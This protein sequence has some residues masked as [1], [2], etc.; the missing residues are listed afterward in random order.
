MATIIEMPKLSDTMSVGTVVKWH[1]QKGEKVSEGDVLA[2]IETD[3]ATMELENFENGVLLKVFVEEG[4]E[5][6]IGSALA[7]V[8]EEGEVI[9]DIEAPD[10]AVEDQAHPTNTE[11]K[12][13][14]DGGESTTLEESPPPAHKHKEYEPPNLDG[15]EE[16]TSGREA[17]EQS[18][19]SVERIL[20]S[21]LAKK[22]AREKEIDLSLVKGSGPRG[23]V[24]KKDVLSHEDIQGLPEKALHSDHAVRPVEVQSSGQLVDQTVP[25]S[26]MRSI[27][28]RRLHESKS[29]IPHF[30]LQKEIDSQ[31]LRLAREAINERLAQR[32][33]PEEKP[34]KLTLNDLILKAC[35]E[36]IKW[37]PEINTSWEN[38]RIR[39][40]GNVHLAFGVAV[41]DGL[42]T[43]V[44]RNAESLDLTSLSLEAKSLIGKARS[45]KLTPDEMTGSTFTVTNLGMFGIDFFSG[46]INPPN[47]AILSVGACLNKP[48]LDSNG[49]LQAGERMTLGLSCDHRLVDGAA[50]AVFLK[51]LGEI[52]ERP[53]SLLV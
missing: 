45:K 28:A 39:Y 29:T 3:K 38:D 25:V 46:I 31:P 49:N 2:E 19:E 37:V 14:G 36:T 20:A 47:A 35:A 52:L 27:I 41:D 11:E 51:R 40:H 30:Y 21:P 18:E 10:P 26:K 24:T 53:A 33:S 44:V 8:G 5:V 16:R 1:K 9:E 34:L 22:I 50:G 23:R 32:C 6:A 7:A 17:K 15:E 42:V 43:P 13:T 12:A 4:V 48:V